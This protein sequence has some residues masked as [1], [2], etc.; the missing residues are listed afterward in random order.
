MRN[1]FQLVLSIEQRHQLIALT[2]LVADEPIIL[3]QLQQWAQLSRTTIL[4]DLDVIEEWL[5]MVDLRLNRRPNY[6]FE[7]AGR[8]SLCVR[9]LA[10]LVMGPNSHLGNPLLEINY[11]NGLTFDM[12]ADADLLPLVKKVG[13]AIQNWDVKRAFSYVAYAESQLGGRFSDDSVRYLGS[14]ICHPR[15]S[16]SSPAI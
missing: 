6:G 7:L 9:Q 2:L 11:A 3:Y 8:K 16:A 5:Q 1:A 14:H 15:L 12:G 13:K 4:K 10:A